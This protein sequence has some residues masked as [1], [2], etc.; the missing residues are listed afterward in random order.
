MNPTEISEAVTF[1]E[2]SWPRQ[3]PDGW[4]RIWIA[5]LADLPA[6]PTWPALKALQECS[7]FPPS[8]ADLH[9]AVAKE[10]GQ[11]PP[12]PE[13][14]A[15]EE[16][17]KKA[18]NAM[19]ANRDLPPAPHPAI[20]Q[21]ISAFGGIEAVMDERDAWRRFWK[22]YR[23]ERIEEAVRARRINEVYAT[24][25]DDGGTPDQIGAG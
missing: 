2:L 16:W 15:G 14:I 8:V 19:Y 22:G 3:W 10:L 7:T 23:A 13:G 12:D 20:R 24:M 4:E 5:A 21:A 17:A 6:E 9:L 1:I 18:R 11:V 25:L